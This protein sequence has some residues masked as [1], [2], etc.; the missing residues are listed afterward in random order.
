[1]QH[2]QHSRMC[3]STEQWT[4]HAVTSAVIWPFFSL[5]PFGLPIKHD[6]CHHGMPRSDVVG[7]AGG[8]LP[9]TGASGPDSGRG[10]PQWQ[11]GQDAAPGACS[12]AALGSAAPR[13]AS[14]AS[15]P[16]GG[17]SRLRERARGACRKCQVA[18]LALCALARAPVTEQRGTMASVMWCSK[19][20]RLFHGAASSQRPVRRLCLRHSLGSRQVTSHMSCRSLRAA[21]CIVCSLASVWHLC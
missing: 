8:W 10:G 17:T 18:H 4:Q 15:A 1:M 5:S 6:A 7:I 12:L 3:L 16:G 11:S 19:I 21:Q 9:T 20:D 2:T 14:S 13:A